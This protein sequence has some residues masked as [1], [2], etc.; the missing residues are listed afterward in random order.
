MARVE[1]DAMVDRLWPDPHP[2]LPL[3]EAFARPRLAQPA[4]RPL[5]A[6]NMVT[7]VDGRAQLEGRAEGLGSRA[8]RRLMQLLRAA[9]DAVASGSGTLAADDFHAR[10]A[11]D[12]A[13]RRSE[14]GLTSQPVA[15]LFAGSGQ[16]PDGRRFLEPR[17]DQR[18][19][20]VLGSG[21]PHAGA[22][23]GGLEAWVA[24]EPRPSPAWILARMAEQGLHSLLLEGGPTIN[25]AFLSAGLVDEIFWTIGPTV[26]GAA[27]LPMI[28]PVPGSPRAA[29]LASVH[30][31]GDELF[32]HYRLAPRADSIGP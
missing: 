8:D 1:R 19:I 16:L 7:S 12:L 24:P 10:L 31:A 4:G 18:R 2:S 15:L 6:L 25:A 29:T 13:A 22:P 3:D 23:P 11:P 5:V 30:R 14:A 27:A 20:L 28:G 32:L 9:F 21:S 17:S 26:V